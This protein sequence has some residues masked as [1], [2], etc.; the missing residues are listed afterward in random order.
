MIAKVA[1]FVEGATECY[2][3]E[4]L[5]NGFLGEGNVEINVQPHSSVSVKLPMQKKYFVLIVD[6]HGDE[7]VKP[8]IK[9]NISSLTRQG[10]SSIV[11]LRDIYPYSDADIHKLERNLKTGIPTAGV[12]IEIFLAKMEIEA[13][14]VQEFSH[15]GRISPALTRTKIKNSLGYDIENDC[16]ENVLHPAELINKIYGLGGKSY[17]KGCHVSQTL[18]ELDLD[19]I[20]CTLPEKMPYFKKIVNKIELMF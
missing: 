2:F 13:W 11:G 19:A 5:L 14:F 10:Y 8:R 18:D 1:F 4:W 17:R 20:F 9:D 6:C 16:A 7:G 15:F 3:L 12:D